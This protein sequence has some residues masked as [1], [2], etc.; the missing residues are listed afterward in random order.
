MER[1]TRKG[2]W[3]KNRY[4]RKVKWMEPKEYYCYP[5]LGESARKLWG[6]FGPLSV[7]WHDGWL[8]P[9]VEGVEKKMMRCV[10][11]RRKCGN[12]Q[13]GHLISSNDVNPLWLTDERLRQRLIGRVMCYPWTHELSEA[14]RSIDLTQYYSWPDDPYPV[15]ADMLLKVY[16]RSGWQRWR[17]E[18][19]RRQR[20]NDWLPRKRTSWGHWIPTH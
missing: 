8:C 3:I 20:T 13:C 9:F 19:E 17:A 7:S 18:L 15:F 6:D 2:L 1:R 4:G 12:H 16:R 5:T 11:G 10:G 14:Y